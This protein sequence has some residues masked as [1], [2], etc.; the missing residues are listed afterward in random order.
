MVVDEEISLKDFGLDKEL[1]NWKLIG[2]A[3]ILLLV[4]VEIK[5]FGSKF[6]LF[7]FIQFDFE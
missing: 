5:V 2:N 4:H 1:Q 6:L 7:F 3:T